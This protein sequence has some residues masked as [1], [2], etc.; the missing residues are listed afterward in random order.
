MLASTVARFR[1]A[2]VMKERL[3]SSARNVPG[4]E[5]RGET[6]KNGQKYDH[7]ILNTY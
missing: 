4:G 3:A 2:F 7:P 5:E 6:A 1:L